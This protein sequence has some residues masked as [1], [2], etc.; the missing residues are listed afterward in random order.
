MTIITGRTV[1]LVTGN[2]LMI[3]VHCRLPVFMAKNTLELCP[4]IGCNVT[5]GA[6]IPFIFVFTR[7]D[8]EELRIVI[9]GYIIPGRCIM[10]FRALCKKPDGTMVRIRRVVIV[11]FMAG[12]AIRRRIRVPAQMAILT[13]KHFMS[14]I[15]HK[16]S[17]G[18]I[19]G[20]I[21]PIRSTVT[22]RTVMGEPFRLVI[23]I[24]SVQVVLIMARPAIRRCSLVTVCMA[25]DT[26]QRDMCSCQWKIGV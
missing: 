17:L 8:R 24:N 21:T 5:I 3:V 25:V 1:V 22:L 4:G 11:R 2:I 26:I 14:T 9:P 20:Y 10:A 6:K 15:Q 19:K 7:I 18:V 16:I 12:E 23:R 13:G